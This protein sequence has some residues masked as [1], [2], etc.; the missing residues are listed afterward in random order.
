MP[1]KPQSLLWDV[2]KAIRG[3][4]EFLEGKDLAAY[5]QSSLLQ[6]AVE[7]K[8]SVIGEALRQMKAQFP[9]EAEAVGIFMSYVGFQSFLLHEYANVNHEIVWEA[10][11]LLPELKAK[12]EQRL[13]ELDR[14]ETSGTMMTSPPRASG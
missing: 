14:A 3:I 5:E 1:R 8:I 9:G 10:V 7:R 13:G 11:L 12:V 6:A 4:E 2:Q